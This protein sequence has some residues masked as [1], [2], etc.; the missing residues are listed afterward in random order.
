MQIASG[1]LEKS[2]VS[3]CVSKLAYSAFS[4]Y[5]YLDSKSW[6]FGLVAKTT[7]GFPN[8]HKYDI[9]ITGNCCSTVKRLCLCS[10][11]RY[12]NMIGNRK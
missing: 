6:S 3:H 11:T 1:G 4:K 5:Q 9:G 12:R 8:P 7:V 2:H 10:Q